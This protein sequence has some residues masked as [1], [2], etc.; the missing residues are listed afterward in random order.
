MSPHSLKRF[1]AGVAVAAVSLPGLALA[2][3]TCVYVMS[4]VDSVTVATPAVAVVVPGSDSETQPVRVH[5]DEQE[6]V[7]L[8]YSVRIPGVDVGTEGDLVFVPGI[9]QHIPSISV[10][11]PELN[12]SP[13]RCVN[14]DGVSTPAVPVKIPASVLTLPGATAEVGAI[15][16]N[17][18]GHPVTAPG[19]VIIFDG[20]TIIIPE[21]NSGVPSVPVGTPNQSITFDVNGTIQT[22]RYLHPNN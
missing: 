8:G 14:V 4:K 19:Q 5:L 21:Q 10:T 16:L 3:P 6:Q 13:N 15:I 17:I 18:V 9:S 20:K 1:L 11:L 12:I 2:E 22:A 7:I